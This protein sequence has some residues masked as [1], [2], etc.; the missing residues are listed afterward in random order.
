MKRFLMLM[1]AIGTIGVFGFLPMH[2]PAG[3]K[4]KPAVSMA[5]FSAFEVSIPG[6]EVVFKMVPI[7]GGTF[8]MGS[9]DSE[10]G[11]KEDEGPVQEVSVPGFWMMET[12]VTWDLYELFIDA[13]RR[14]S[15][16]YLNE[17]IKSA[18]DAVTRPSTPYLDPSFGM[19]KYG[20]PAVSMT[21]Y[22]AL[23]FCK[24][25]SELTGELYR[26]PTEAEWEYACRAGTQTAY[27]FGDDVSELSKYAWYYDNSDDKYHEVAS[28]EPNPWGL[29]DMHGNVAEWTLDQYQP[30][31]YNALKD[32]IH[33]P[34]RRPTALHPRSVRGGSWDDDPEQL[35]SAA[36]LSSTPN[37]QKRDPQIP[38]SFW[39]NTD[40]PFVGFRLVRPAES[41]SREDKDLFWMSVLDDG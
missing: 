35:R 28:K 31:F 34:W 14:A 12:E 16:E 21:Q 22:S 6:T 23:M 40:A 41:P 20:F 4:E 8:Q 26:L 33:N 37:W 39:W 9:P 25:L 2:E 13:D 3:T 15:I 18:A 24:W 5:D 1:L 17:E 11:R 10:P 32:K 19:G 36:R 30:D 27:Y 29:Y 38:K 7:Q